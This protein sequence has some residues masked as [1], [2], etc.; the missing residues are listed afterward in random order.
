MSSGIPTGR[1]YLGFILL[2][3]AVI[4]LA[5]MLGVALFAGGHAIAGIFTILLPTYGYFRHSFSIGDRADHLIRGPSPELRR[6]LAVDRQRTAIE[7]GSPSELH[8]LPTQNPYMR[9]AK[10][11][12]FFGAATFVP[13]LLLSWACADPVMFA[14]LIPLSLVFIGEMARLLWRAYR[15]RGDNLPSAWLSL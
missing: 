15:W 10:F 6:I 2:W 3:G 12:F 11:S 9:R 5:W 4:P 13:L 7:A 8:I 1:T 14:Y